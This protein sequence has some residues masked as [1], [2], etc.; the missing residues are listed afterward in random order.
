MRFGTRFRFALP[1]AGAERAKLTLLD[2][3]GRRVRTFTGPF[4]AG[5][6]ELAWDGLDGEG[7]PVRSGLYFYELDLPG[8]KIS[9]RLV[10][11]R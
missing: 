10:V 1:A 6:N 11:V 9:H 5:I 2:P 3:S 4:A 8:A 7:R